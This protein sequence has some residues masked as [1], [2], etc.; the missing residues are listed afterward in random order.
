MKHQLTL[1]Y[2]L[3]EGTL[4][5][6]LDALS[7]GVAKA[8]QCAHCNRVT[9]PPE[10][11]CACGHN[12]SKPADPDWITLSGEGDVVQCTTGVGGCFALVRF[13]GA[14]NCGVCRSTADVQSG[15]RVG[16]IPSRRGRPALTVTP[17]NSDREHNVEIID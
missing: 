3:G 2:D 16:L 9:F 7:R 17:L 10:R 5:P 13:D 1:E 14:D 15:N 12:E 8:T 4:A 6:F 11:T